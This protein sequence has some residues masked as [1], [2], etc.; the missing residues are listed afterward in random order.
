[1]YHLCNLTRTP[2]QDRPFKSRSPLN[3]FTCD[4]SKH[5]RNLK[6]INCNPNKISNNKYVNKNTFLVSFHTLF[7]T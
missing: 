7:I 6:A 4:A 3:A 1:M 2:P 5:K